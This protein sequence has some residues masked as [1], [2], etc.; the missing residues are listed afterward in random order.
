M[1]DCVNT[2]DR[3]SVRNAD[4]NIFI[5]IYR[6]RHWLIEASR[7]CDF[8]NATV[9]RA[10]SRN[11][12]DDAGFRVDPP[13]P[14][15]AGIGNIKISEGI[16]C[17]T[18]GP[19]QTGQIGQTSITTETPAPVSRN[20]RYAPGGGYFQDPVLLACDNIDIPIAVHDDPCGERLD[21]RTI[22]AC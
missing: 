15:V 17:D 4:I 20:N 3:I 14:V 9:Q 1:G 2:L 18:D 22:A 8:A 5:S 7:S 10:S 21:H 11:G 12:R 6:D 16:D 19:I 13:D